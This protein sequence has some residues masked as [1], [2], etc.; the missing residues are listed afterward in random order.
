MSLVD[1]L[2][3]LTA[4]GND[5]YTAGDSTYWSDTQLQACLDAHRKLLDFQPVEW[6]PS[7]IGGGS[8]EYTRA[9]VG[10]NLSLEPNAGTVQDGQGGTVSGWTL[11]GDGWMHFT[12][13]QA[14]S[15][16]YYTGYAYN[17][18][19]A[20]AD[21]CTA[22]ASALKTQVDVTS[23]DQSLKLSQ[24]R[25]SLLEMAREFRKGA[26]LSTGDLTRGDAQ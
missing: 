18:K 19:A 24:K 12:A 6:A 21:V 8:V 3:L 26:P 20:A 1:D 10:G 17:I 4:A 7:K 25:T 16:R 22:W 9:Y 11:D 13:D 15:A 23:D 5:E 2:R 14:G